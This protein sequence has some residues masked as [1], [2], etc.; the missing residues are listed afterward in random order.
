MFLECFEAGVVP[1][2]ERIENDFLIADQ[3]ET[4]Y[5][6]LLIMARFHETDSPKVN[7]IK[8]VVDSNCRYN[9]NNFIQK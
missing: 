1:S 3:K 4:L 6:L 7:L 5:L 2:T 8:S 9:N